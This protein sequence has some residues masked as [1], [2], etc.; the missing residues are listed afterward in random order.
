MREYLLSHLDDAVVVRN[1]AALLAKD[2]TSTALLLAYIAELDA[3]RLYVPAGYPSMFAYCTEEL[4][5]SEDAAYKRIAAA[6]AARKFPVLLN[7][8]AEGRLHV[9]GV[10]VL[11]PH[12]N[13]E[14]LDEL[15]KAATHRKKSDIEEML[16]RRFATPDIAPSTGLPAKIRPLPAMT[17]RAQ[18]AP[19]RVAVKNLPLLESVQEDSAAPTGN[20]AQESA[21]PPA[22]T[23]SS[24]ESAAERFVLQ[25]TIDKSTR[26]KLQYLQALLSHAV[27][28]ADLAQ[29][30]DRALDMAIQQ[31]EKQKL[32][33]AS[34]LRKS[35][36]GSGLHQ[37]RR[38]LGQDREK[39]E[40]Y[41]PAPVR[42]AVWERDQG[43]CTFV[44]AN[45]KR[46]ESRMF[47]EFDHMDPVARGGTATL[48]RTRIRC[49]AHNQ[50]EAECVFGAGFMNQK[51]HEARIAREKARERTPST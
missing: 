24:A 15:I 9:S 10:V 47:L 35:S 39:R 33:N 1:L 17:S 50:Y 22:Q 48:E 30:L 29:V 11:A 34:R 16:A 38:S 46:C 3:R 42:R 40:R 45:G 18:L 8:V 43:Q 44:S 41:V 20:S 4:H 27:P 32:G 49:R 37:A 7:A 13:S 14:N 28:K 12:L 23:G 51:R 25:V 6:R 36:R 19:G 21:P 5:L 26:D 2:Q 31:A